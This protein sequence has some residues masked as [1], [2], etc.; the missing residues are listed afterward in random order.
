MSTYS[1]S[2][3]GS[4]GRYVFTFSRWAQI[5]FQ[6]DDTI[7]D[8]PAIQE[9]SGIA[10]ICQ[11]FFSCLSHPGVGG[12]WH[13]IEVSFC[14][15]LMTNAVKQ[16]SVWVLDIWIILFGDMPVQLFFVYLIKRGLSAFFLLIWRS[17]MCIVDTSPWLMTD[18]CGLSLS[19]IF[20]WTNSF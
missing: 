20:W 11:F 14:I 1:R 16:L 17:S 3:A 19:S 5:V 18:I 10:N 6:S 4:E 9:S 13:C 8:S 15:F 7:L 12:N 2:G